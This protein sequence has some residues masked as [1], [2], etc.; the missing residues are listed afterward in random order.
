M[1]GLNPAESHSRSLLHRLAG[2]GVVVVGIRSEG[3]ASY[4]GEAKRTPLLLQGCAAL[5]FLLG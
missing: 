1:L 5:L 3:P 2:V 4:R